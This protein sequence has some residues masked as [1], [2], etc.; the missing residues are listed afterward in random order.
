MAAEGG[1]VIGQANLPEIAEVKCSSLLAGE[2]GSWIAKESLRRYTRTV[3]RLETV[4]EG[5]YD[6]V[7]DEDAALVQH[8]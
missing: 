6:T 5:V 4:W 7:V 2:T 1:V 8:H 3:I